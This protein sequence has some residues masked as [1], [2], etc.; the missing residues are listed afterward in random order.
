MYRTCGLPPCVHKQELWRNAAALDQQQ[1][2]SLL[3]QRVMDTAL[4]SSSPPLETDPPVSTAQEPLRA[5]LPTSLVD[6][7]D[8][9][10]QLGASMKPVGEWHVALERIA[11]HRL[12]VCSGANS[13]ILV[14]EGVGVGVGVLAACA[15]GVK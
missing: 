15:S 12:E 5:A 8:E 3:C 9:Q 14:C 6:W 4:P 13:A 10:T 1:E 11:A 2:A 7:L